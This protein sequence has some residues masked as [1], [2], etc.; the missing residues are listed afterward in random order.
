MAEGRPFHLVHRR[1]LARRLRKPVDLRGRVVAHPDVADEPLV[2][3]PDEP[4]PERS[5]GPSS[6]GRWISVRSA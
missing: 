2:P 4:F 5:P 1:D 6:G 3:R